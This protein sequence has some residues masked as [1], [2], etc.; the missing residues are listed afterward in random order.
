VAVFSVS[1]IFTAV[2]IVAQPSAVTVPEDTLE[3]RLLPSWMQSR[4][5]QERLGSVP[6]ESP[7]E[8]AVRVL[9]EQL[10][11]CEA[12]TPG[13]LVV[14]DVFGEGATEIA[15]PET[16]ESGNPNIIATCFGAPEHD[17]IT[18]TEAETNARLFAAARTALPAYIKAALEELEEHSQDGLYCN[19]NGCGEWPCPTVLRYA[20][21]CG[22]RE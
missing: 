8:H 15:A 7:R 22:W 1:W 20:R 11:L 13:P 4:H 14:E 16:K 9:R 5:T 3:I 10:T 17:Q 19:V 21:A 12:A 2:S 6:T 18:Q